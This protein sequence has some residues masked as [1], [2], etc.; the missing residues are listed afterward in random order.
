M[1]PNGAEK[2]INVL[3]SINDNEKTLLK[4][5]VDGLKGNIEKGVT[6]AHNPPQK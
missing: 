1:Q 6:F 2:A 5:C 4:A 3:S